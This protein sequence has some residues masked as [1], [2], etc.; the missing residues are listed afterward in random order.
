MCRPPVRAIT[1]ISPS[2]SSDEEG[3]GQMEVA[4]AEAGQI[5]GVGVEEGEVIVAEEEHQVV[6]S[7]PTPSLPT[8]S[9]VDDHEIDHIPYRSWCP[10]CVEG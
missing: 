9:E 1:P 7:L 5:C 3:C 2:F 4:A 8:Q 10:G 6:K